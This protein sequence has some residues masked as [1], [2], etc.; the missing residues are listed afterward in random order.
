M[1][2]N[3]KDLT[4]LWGGNLDCNVKTVDEPVKDVYEI[5]SWFKILPLHMSEEGMEE[6]P[7]RLK[8]VVFI[9]KECRL[10]VVKVMSPPLRLLNF[11]ICLD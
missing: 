8:R 6:I 1:V 2:R 4:S 7:K 3:L 11:R 9:E 10:T 5:I